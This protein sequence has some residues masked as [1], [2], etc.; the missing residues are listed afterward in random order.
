MDG[1]SAIGLVSSVA[2]VGEFA[3]Q[4]L[5]KLYRYYVDVK[6]GPARAAELR[7]EVGFALS[8]LNA[9]CSALNSGTITT[10]NLSEM[11]TAASRFQKVLEKIDT[12]IQPEC[13]QG[14]GKLKWPF[15]KEDNAQLIAEIET[16][17]SG[18]SLALNID[19]RYF[20]ATFILTNQSTNTRNSERCLTYKKSCRW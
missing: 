12:R 11:R 9:I 7:E 14:F 2:Q 5:L 17:K 3:G 1:L 20:P 19:Q 10:F 13:L 4:V 8:Q 15:K 16:C 6:E 18:F